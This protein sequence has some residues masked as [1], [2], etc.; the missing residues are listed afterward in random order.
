MS[1]D[2][3]TF[4]AQA[5]TLKSNWDKSSQEVEAVSAV[6]GQYIAR[7]A[8]NYIN[9]MSD[10]IRDLEKHIMDRN[11]AAARQSLEKAKSSYDKAE[12]AA[13][14]M[15]KFANAKG[16][17]DGLSLMYGVSDPDTSAKNTGEIASMGNITS[18]AA[19]MGINSV[20]GFYTLGS[21]ALGEVT[22]IDPVGIVGEG[23]DKVGSAINNTKV[24]QAFQSGV[25]KTLGAG[26]EAGMKTRF[27][28]DDR[29]VY[30][31]ANGQTYKTFDDAYNV[32]KAMG[33]QFEPEEIVY[34]TRTGDIINKVGTGLGEAKENITDVINPFKGF[35]SDP[36]YKFY[37]PATW[38][39]WGSLR[40]NM[41]E[42][43]VQSIDDREEWDE[44]AQ[45]FGY[46]TFDVERMNENDFKL[47]K[48]E[49]DDMV[50]KEEISDAQAD[51]EMKAAAHFFEFGTGHATP[52]R[53]ETHKDPDGKFFDSKVAYNANY[54]ATGNNSFGDIDPHE[55]GFFDDSGRATPELLN[56]ARMTGRKIELYNVADHEVSFDGNPLWEPAVTLDPSAEEFWHEASMLMRGMPDAPTKTINSETEGSE[57]EKYFFKDP[58][59]GEYKT[60]DL[61]GDANKQSNNWTFD[62]DYG[63]M[64]AG[65]HD[66]S[67]DPSHMGSNWYE[68]DFYGPMFMTPDPDNNWAYSVDHGWIYQAPDT[69]HQDNGNWWWNAN[70]KGWTW[71]YTD[72]NGNQW[73]YGH[74][75]QAWVSNENASSGNWNWLGQEEESTETAQEA[76]NFADKVETKVDGL[77]DKIQSQ[78]EDKLTDVNERIQDKMDAKMDQVEEKQGIIEFGDLEEKIASKV[79]S[80]QEKVQERAPKCRTVSKRGFEFEICT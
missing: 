15:D 38:T 8:N 22:G 56:Y 29:V 49:Y 48:S 63:L 70:L 7:S 24:G 66:Q 53:L 75:Q 44:Y 35:K 34:K 62:Q 41:D 72:D 73:L 52:I 32:N 43:K 14:R 20:L 65:D 17:Y 77:S 79:E 31:A 6:G 4:L 47:M 37:N 33:I 2:L 78:V 55:A 61:D 11:A 40:K 5:N 54:E 60:Y 28:G 76:T 68:N 36:N 58:Q 42:N 30:K 39:W 50:R 1:V 45:T 12:S 27:F 3:N 16:I 21:A 18:G 23:L 57:L 51:A 25:E 74:D 10:H 9:S 46:S 69:D 59:S 67:Q 80:V 13:K 19:K 64:F 26:V 71:N